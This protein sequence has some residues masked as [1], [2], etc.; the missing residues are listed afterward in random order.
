MLL[1]AIFIC[2]A[3]ILF[4]YITVNHRVSHWCAAQTEAYHQI[5]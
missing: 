5:L 3:R 2:R 1:S 4:R